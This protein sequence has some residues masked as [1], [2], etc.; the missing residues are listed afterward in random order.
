M[1]SGIGKK[2]SP[3]AV[4]I[5]LGLIAA[6]AAVLFLF[7]RVFHIMPLVVLIGALLAFPAGL[8]FIIFSFVPSCQRCRKELTFKKVALSSSAQS[9]LKRVYSRNPVKDLTALVAKYAAAASA[10]SIRLAC[11]YCPQCRAV[12]YLKSPGYA[13]RVISG[14][15]VA[16]M[17]AAMAQPADSASA[18]RRPTRG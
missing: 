12:G 8:G 7:Y 17:L 13:E 18:A 2:F 3:G 15:D 14:K 1:A 11:W 5:G 6:G 4:G 9:E 16:E 10:Q